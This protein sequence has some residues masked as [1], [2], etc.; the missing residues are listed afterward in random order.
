MRK[1]LLLLTIIASALT[2]FAQTTPADDY[3]YKGVAHFDNNN[4][5]VAVHSFDSA[6]VLMPAYYDAMNYRAMT[7]YN[8][9]MYNEAIADYEN[10]IAGDRNYFAAYT[11]MANAYLKLNNFDK[12]REVMSMASSAGA[13]AIDANNIL[14][15]I[16]YMQGDYRKAK[17][18]FQAL[19]LFNPDDEAGNYNLGNTY[20]QLKM[21]DSAA[22]YHQQALRLRPNYPDY[23]FNLSLDYSHIDKPAMQQEALTIA[24][25]LLAIDPNHVR[26]NTEMAYLMVKRPGYDPQQVMPYIDRAITL[27][28]E[29]NW[30]AY[31]TRG[32]LYTNLGRYAEAMNDFNRSIEFF[33]ANAGAYMGRGTIYRDSGMYAEAIKDYLRASYL[34][35]ENTELYFLLADINARLGLQQ[36]ADEYFQRYS[37]LADNQARARSRINTSKAFAM[38]LK[39]RNKQA[40]D[41]ANT[42]L[43]YDSTYAAAMNNK[44]MALARLGKTDSGLYFINRSLELQS[45]NAQAFHNR[46]YAYAR[47]GKYEQ[48]CIDLRK[49]LELHYSLQPDS[50]L[51]NIAKRCNLQH[52]SA[53]PKRPVPV[54]DNI[55]KDMQLEAIKFDSYRNLPE[56]NNIFRLENLILNRSHNSLNYSLLLYPNPAD[57]RVSIA[58]SQFPRDPFSLLLFNSGGQMVRSNLNL[59]QTDTGI[60]FEVS[61]LPNGRYVVMFLSRNALLAK[62][63]L[64]V[65][66]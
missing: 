10:I 27:Q 39:G 53:Y 7:R 9:G 18:Y 1:H 42:A 52:L 54:M 46:A 60:G 13:P 20:F 11:N 40:L 37:E 58:P 57:Q 36:E 63:I 17:E 49:A 19:V 21:Y 29:G 8:M 66:H 15:N 22:F 32:N 62:S 50:L 30:L 28:P 59:R 61:D 5:L 26:A 34:D 33:P 14:G 48:A 3:F 35:P 23:M 2:G 16:S 41:L 56:T 43:Y 55:Y 38:L 24:N 45:E 12:A 6:I 47:T 4:Y 25:N 64:W 51:L 31:S 44:G 65:S